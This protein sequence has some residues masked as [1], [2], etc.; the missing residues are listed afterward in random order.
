MM[1]KLPKVLLAAPIYDGKSYCFEAW[2]D[3]LSKLTAP[4]DLLLV[5]N[6]EKN[7]FHKKIIS[8]GINCIYLKHKG[9]SQFDR[10]AAS[11]NIIRQH[12]LTNGYDY[13]FSLETDIF[14]PVNIIEMLLTMKR[15]VSAGWYHIGHG[16]SSHPMIQLFEETANENY[17]NTW[18]LGKDAITFLDGS[19][20]VV[21]HAGLG[22]VMI[23]SSVLEKIKFRYDHKNQIYPDLC[24]AYDLFMEGI[25]F[26]LDTSIICEH[27]N[28]SSGYIPVSNKSLLP[29]TV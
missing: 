17:R 22:C 7:N 6:S 10:M 19:V 2:L 20:K 8:R 18:W 21:F 5:D 29:L 26:Y 23:H 27:R 24:F 14:P 12:A 16:A 1:I 4:F 13:W 28:D 15:T 9:R 3:H 11:L 25:D